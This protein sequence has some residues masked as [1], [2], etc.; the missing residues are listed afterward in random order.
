MPKTGSVEFIM[1]LG[2]Y[3]MQAVGDGCP[4]VPKQNFHL[5]GP[6]LNL[7]VEEGSVFRSQ[8]EDQIK[9]DSQDSMPSIR[10]LA[11]YQAARL[12]LL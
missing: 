8:F 2:H 3:D 7:L 12:S 11:R 9:K 6:S 5:A 4:N 10:L 1:D